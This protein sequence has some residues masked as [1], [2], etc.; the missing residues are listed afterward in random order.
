MRRRALIIAAIV[1]SLFAL[2]GIAW[3]SI[4]GPDG[5]IHGCYKN[6]N[7]A[8]GAV[9]VVDHTASCPSGYTTLNWSQTGPTGPAGP[10]GPQGPAGTVA[11]SL[12]QGN[13]EA[14]PGTGGYIAEVSLS[15]PTGKFA[16]SGGYRY[17]NAGFSNPA[18]VKPVS[19]GYTSFSLLVGGVGWPTA[20]TTRV[21]ADSDGTLYVDLFC[22]SP[23]S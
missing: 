8:Q 21:E 14:A 2:G 15:C 7:P 10:T 13:A 1:L 19:N 11:W 9:I 5:V 16:V 6:S 4:P 3:A 22:A 20:W 18:G 12:V 17:D 23:P